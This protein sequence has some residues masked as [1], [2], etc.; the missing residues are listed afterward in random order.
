MLV[1]FETHPIQYHAPVYRAV[2][3]EFQIP[4]TVIYGSDFSVAGYHDQ[5]FDASFA[6]DTDLLSGYQ[7]VFLSKVSN[8]G[9]SSAERVSSVGLSRALRGLSPRA[10]L[11]GGYGHTYHRA[12]FYAAFRHGSPILFRAETNDNGHGHRRLPR[13]IVRDATL[14]W[15]YRR[16]SKLLFIGQSSREHYARLGATGDKLVFSPYCVDVTAF[17][18]DEQ[19]RNRLRSQARTRLGIAADHQ[20][21]LFSGKLIE[22]KGPDLLLSAIKQMEEQLR[23]TITVLFVGSGKLKSRLQD[24]A[25]IHPEIKVIFAGFQNQR[26]LS[27]FYHAADLLVLPSHAETWGLVVNEA[28]GHGLPCVVSSGVGCAPDLVEPGVSGEI[29]E[30]GSVDRLVSAIRRALKLTGR[31]DIRERCRS[32]VADYTVSRAAQG[33]AEAYRAVTS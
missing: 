15:C 28:L 31:P 20:V 11:I 10:V 1:A 13:R 3:T 21:I 9:A 4:V 7:P 12:A 22:T 29:F 24:S 25:E 6:W 32:K 2:Q 27:P 17:E 18:P 19:A 30:T 23:K 16:C 5:D 26:Q 33:I 14:R 8:G